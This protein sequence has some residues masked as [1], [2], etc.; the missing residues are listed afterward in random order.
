MKITVF[1]D[2]MLHSIEES[3][4]CFRRTCCFHLL[5]RRESHAG[6][7]GTDIWRRGKEMG[8][9]VSQW[10]PAVPKSEVKHSRGTRSA[11]HW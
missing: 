9:T 8:L 11:R 7:D 10:E 6:N 2:L 4:Q 1:W 5:G 3:Y